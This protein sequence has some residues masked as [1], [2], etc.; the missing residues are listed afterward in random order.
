MSDAALPE[1]SS[2]PRTRW[3]RQGHHERAP[4]TLPG[5]AEPPLLSQLRDNLL[6]GYG[7][8]GSDIGLA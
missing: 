3:L 2:A 6:V 7:T 4:S 8:A 5:S 1:V